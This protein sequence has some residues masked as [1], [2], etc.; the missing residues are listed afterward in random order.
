MEHI[1]IKLSIP[2]G[3]AIV[4]ISAPQCGVILPFMGLGWTM[5]KGVMELSPSLGLGTINIALFMDGLIFTKARVWSLGIGMGRCLA[6][7]PTQPM[8]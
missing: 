3:V 7:N 4:G 1:G 6:P 2:S 5:T 8:G